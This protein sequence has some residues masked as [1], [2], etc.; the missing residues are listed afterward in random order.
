MKAIMANAE[1]AL[2][3]KPRKYTKIP[4][5]KKSDIV[6]LVQVNQAVG[7]H[8]LSIAPKRKKITGATTKTIASAKKLSFS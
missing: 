5:P 4:K 3:A 2:G 1:P 7:K 6:E 8:T